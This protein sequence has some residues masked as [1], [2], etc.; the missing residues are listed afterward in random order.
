MPRDELEITPE[1]LLNAY[2]AGV[3][4][5][6]EHRDGLTRWVDPHRRGIIPLDALHVSRSL[7]RRIR[8]GGFEMRVDSAFDAVVDACADRE[9]TWINAEIR[10][11]YSRLHAM[12]QAHSVEFWQGGTLRGGL[13]GVRLGAAFFGESMFSTATDASKIALVWLVARLRAGGFHLLDTQFLTEHLASM[14]GVEIGR[15][16]YRRRLAFATRQAADW[17]ALPPDAPAEDVLARVRPGSV[18]G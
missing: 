7:A 10:G 12:R 8:R 6:A 15:G 17:S 18:G 4:P 14:G 3:F 1:L 9:E 16:A 11:L 13:Y 5:M 2:A